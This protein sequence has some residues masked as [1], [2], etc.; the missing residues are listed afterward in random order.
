M[1]TSK[2]YAILWLIIIGISQANAESFWKSNI[3]YSTLT[4]ANNEVEV[5]GSEVTTAQISIPA[6]VTYEGVTYSVTS[7]GN[8]ALENST[9]SSIVIPSSIKKIGSSAFKGAKF[10]SVKIPNSVTIIKN[11]TF[12]NCKQLTSVTLNNNITEMGNSAFSGCSS[13]TGITLP[14]KLT[15]ISESCFYNSG[16]TAISFGGKIKTIKK[17]AFESCK[18]LNNINVPNNVEDIEESAFYNCSNLSNVTLGTGIKHIGKKAFYLTLIYPKYSNDVYIGKYLIKGYDLDN[19]H[20]G[21]VLF[22][23]SSCTQTKSGISTCTIPSSVKYV[24]NYVFDNNTKISRVIFSEGVISIGNYLFGQN[25]SNANNSH[26]GGTIT[27]PST[28]Q[29][30]GDYA[31]AYGKSVEGWWT[32][33]FTI[34]WNIPNFKDFT[35]ENRPLRESSYSKII[36]G[37]NVEHIPAYLCYGLENGVTS[38]NLSNSLRSIGDYAFAGCKQLSHIEI[39]SNLD[40]IGAYAFS[41]CTALTHLE[42]PDNVAYIGEYAFA[43]CSGVTQID[44]GTGISEIKDGV[45]RSCSKLDHIYIPSNITKLGNEAF[46]N[47]SKLTRL[48]NPNNSI[49]SIGNNCFQRCTTLV[50]FDIP[51]SVQTLGSYAFANCTALTTLTW[52]QNLSA[53]Q[54]GT[55]ADCSKLENVEL[56]NNITSIGDSCFYNCIKL[57]NF[58]GDSLQNIGSAAF[59]NCSVLKNFTFENKIRS[60]GNNLFNGCNALKVFTWNV[61]NYTF[62]QYTPF[63]GAE[64]DIRAN[65]D[66]VH[67]GNMVKTIPQKLCADMKNLKKVFVGSNVNEMNYQ[68]ILGC[69]SLFE[70][71][72][73]Q[74]NSNLT[75]KDGVVFSSDT[76]ELK[77]YPPAKIGTTYSIPLPVEA[78]AEGA[79]YNC[80]K[81]TSMKMENNIQSIGES[82]F[83]GCM[84]LGSITFGEKVETIGQRAFYNDSILSSIT[85]NVINIPSLTPDVFLYYRSKTHQEVDH[86]RKMYLYIAE[87][88]KSEYEALPVWKN[89]IMITHRAEGIWKVVWKDWNNTILKE[90]YVENG[91]SATPPDEPSREGYIFTGW[92]KSYENVTSDLTIKALYK[93]EGEGLEDVIGEGQCTNKILYEGQIYILRGEKIYTLQGQEMK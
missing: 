30:L 81:I 12:E 18:S 17:S 58:K 76:T 11:S 8:N 6:Q 74:E 53:L 40:S 55:F 85:S 23:D 60:L 54:N 34:Y 87:H 73:A 80:L 57:T 89:M 71:N 93:K 37:D 61:P 7:I 48:T 16:L 86:T 4:G 1:R 2:F 82:A 70:I 26:R 22:A 35:Y 28:I 83:E 10:Q 41:N 59:A 13:L 44:L 91:K 51:T 90:E 5:I 32:T 39:P 27:L 79:F 15:E 88:R 49:I 24:G 67:F 63:F 75:S 50:N 3:Q 36:I 52:G 92:D 42:I 9:C 56:I 46:Q 66:T 68:Q 29:E 45:F 33:T 43:S 20:T 64:Y 31:F 69:N 47:C 14:S 62:S 78:I 77:V 65:I 21:T 84:K 72:V 38:V 19:I 25:K